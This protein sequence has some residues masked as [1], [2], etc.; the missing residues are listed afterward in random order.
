MKKIL[1]I[2]DEIDIC[3]M[4]KEYLQ[5]ENY[6]V[7]TANDGIS[8]LS[9]IKN[10]PDI[11]LLDINMPGMDGFK[12]CNRIREEITCPIVFLSAR[13]QEKDKINGFRVG[14]DD[15]IEKPFS[16]EELLARIEAHL[17]REERNRKKT[18][19]LMDEIMTIDFDGGKVMCKGINIG[20]TKTEFLIVELLVTHPGQVFEKEYIYENV[21]GFDGDADSSII[22]E[23]IRRLRKKLKK[24]TEKE[25]IETVWGVGYRWIG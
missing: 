7:Y 24:Y 6:I 1:V 22:M 18:K 15:Y 19:V 23:H 8:A 5:M 2:D 21:R 11:I 25:Y 3:N 20:L 4:L 10:Q 17:R 16:I 13:T 9:Q 12:I 14:A